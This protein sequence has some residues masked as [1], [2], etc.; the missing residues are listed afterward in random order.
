[1]STY[2]RDQARTL[3]ALPVGRDGK[4]LTGGE[5]WSWEHV[6]EHA[7]KE[8]ERELQAMATAD[9]LHRRQETMAWLLTLKEDA[10]RELAKDQGSAVEPAA[11]DDTGRPPFAERKNKG[12]R[13]SVKAADDEW[14]MRLMNEHPG[15]MVAVGAAFLRELSGVSVKTA[16]NRFWA[17]RKR[18]GLAPVNP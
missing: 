14:L 2:W 10:E 5:L 17:A 1:M 8:R 13:P 11:V 3:P 4:P 9:E 16:K 15:D 18:S 12:G 6:Q 7:E